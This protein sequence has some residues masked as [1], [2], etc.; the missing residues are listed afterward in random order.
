MNGRHQRA[1]GT[2]MVYDPSGQE[3]DLAPAQFVRGARDQ[4][5]VDEVW[6]E[7]SLFIGL[8]LLT[9][10]VLSGWTLISHRRI[11][12]FLYDANGFLVLD[13]IELFDLSGVC[14]GFFF[15]C[16]WKWSQYCVFISVVIITQILSAFSWWNQNYFFSS[17]L[18]NFQM[19]KTKTWLV[20]EWSFPFGINR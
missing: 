7:I 19:L 10:I 15:F 12:E 5:G 14:G 17:V 9:F 8:N 6:G 16:Y 3:W 2:H 18:W 11:V 1:T 13:W 20:Q 4:W